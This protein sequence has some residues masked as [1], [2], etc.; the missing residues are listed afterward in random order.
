MGTSI[1]SGRPDNVWGGGVRGGG[2]GVTLPWACIPSQGEGR[3]DAASHF[4]LRK[5]E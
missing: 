4:T 3:S 2:R 5:L 1:L